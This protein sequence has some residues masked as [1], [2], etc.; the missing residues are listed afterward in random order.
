MIEVQ[1]SNCVQCLFRGLLLDRHVCLAT[2]L[3]KTAGGLVSLPTYLPKDQ[4]PAVVEFGQ[5]IPEVPDWCPLYFSYLVIGLEGKIPEYATEIP[6]L[7]PDDIGILHWEEGERY[8]RGDKVISMGAPYICTGEHFSGSDNK[9]GIG[10]R[11]TWKSFWLFIGKP[12]T[13]T[14]APAIPDTTSEVDNWEHEREYMAGDRVISFAATYVCVLD[15]Y[16]T[17][18]TRPGEVDN[19]EQFWLYLGESARF[20]GAWAENIEYSEHDKVLVVPKIYTCTQGHVSS[21][22]RHPE[23]GLDRRDFWV[24]GELDE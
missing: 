19:W 13:Y 4:V 24:S 5:V 6:N 1:V 17:A 22:S 12:G 11:E 7:W 14:L 8:Q 20:R 16:S 2:R 10:V 3:G 18:S 9:P 15:H 23:G 21:R